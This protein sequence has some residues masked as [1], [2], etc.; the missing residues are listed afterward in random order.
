MLTL[1]F[2]LIN[3]QTAE[4][5]AL[6]FVELLSCYPEQSKGIESNALC[7]MRKLPAGTKL[8]TPQ[9]VNNPNCTAVVGAIEPV[10]DGNDNPFNAPILTLQ[11]CKWKPYFGII[12]AS[13]VISLSLLKA[14]S[15]SPSAVSN[16]LLLSLKTSQLW[17]TVSLDQ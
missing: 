11:N 15:I 16:S 4:A 6:E 3:L 10:T 8:Q 5:K 9:G 2:L 7:T 12:S 13:K 17:K 14:K 1:S